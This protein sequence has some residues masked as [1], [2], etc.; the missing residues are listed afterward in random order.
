MRSAAQ[1]CWC[2]GRSAAIAHKRSV[3]L[4][5]VPCG[6]GELIALLLAIATVVAGG[7]SY[8]EPGNPQSAAPAVQPERQVAPPPGSSAAQ[9]IAFYQKRLQNYPDDVDALEAL[10]GAEAELK[11]FPAAI[12]AYRRVLAS[13]PQDRDAQI[14]LARLLGWNRQYDDSIGAFRAMLEQAPEDREALEGLASVQVWSKRLE[15][16]AA[17]Y[18]RLASS[19]PEEHRYLFEAARLEA[20]THQYA[21][22]RERLTTLLALDPQNLDARLLLAQLESRQGQYASALRQFDRVLEDRPADPGAL[23]GA[24]RARYYLGELERADAEATRLVEGQPQN[25]DALFLLASIE[26]AR[27][28]RRRAR[29][30]LN[31]AERLS[32]HSP[33]VSELREKLWSES[34]TVL[35]LAA[36][37]THEIGSPNVAGIPASLIEEDLRS[38]SFGSRLDFKVLPR[39]TSTVSFDSFPVQIPSGLFGGAAAPSQFLYQQNTRIFSK[40]NLRGGIGLEHFGPGVPVNLP[41]GAGPQPGATAAPIGFAGG[42]IAL[43][44]RLS[45]DFTWSHFAVTYTPLAARL[46]VLSSRMEGGPVITFD[47]RTTLRLSYYQERFS[48]E[49]YDQS[50]HAI[51]ATSNQ[52][53]AGSLSE[54]GRGGTLTLNRRLVERERLALDAGFSALAFGYDGPRHGVFLGFFTPR[55]YQREMVTSRLS[56]P[57]SKKLGYDLSASFGVQQADQGQAIKRALILD[58]GFTFKLAPYLSGSVGYT[59]YDSVQ[60]LGIVRGNGAHLGIDWRF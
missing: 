30:L 16:A 19:H 7:L 60:S 33:E 3:S 51:G 42:T 34:S 9:R 27:G 57:V 45:F 46:G 54:K 14:Q 31:S 21:A 12:L 23:L 4:R 37:Y 28:N 8:A 20:S 44:P 55:L 29:A 49:R 5:R 13:H 48:T 2:R 53:S 50:V 26:R 47:P 10:A 41:N 38:F 17:T 35:H 22:A 52:T 36:G 11:N 40:L 18:G 6:R 39:S 32:P 25:Y 58:P 59:H 56:G 43:N 15:E 1:P 24:A